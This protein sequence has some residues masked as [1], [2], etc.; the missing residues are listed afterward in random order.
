MNYKISW[1]VKDPCLLR[2][3]VRSVGAM[4]IDVNKQSYCSGGPELEERLRK[5]ERLGYLTYY[6][7]KEG[8]W[9]K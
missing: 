5:G 7:E 8:R 6:K 1:N 4:G 3:L 9:V 2:S